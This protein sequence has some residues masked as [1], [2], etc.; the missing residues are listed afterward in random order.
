MSLGGPCETPKCSD[1]SLNQAVESL[2][3]LGVVVS[4]AAGNDGSNACFGSPN[5]ATHAI[6][7]GA[8]DDKDAVSYWSNIGQCVDVF[9]P[10]VDIISACASVLCPEGNE[11][12]YTKMSGTS[13]ACPH[14]SV[15]LHTHQK[16]D[17]PFL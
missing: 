17:V 9:S 11:A 6:V 15:I 5:A 12:A 7:T 3:G 16:C 4:V 10:G 14:T 13:M 1:D 8:F 2:V